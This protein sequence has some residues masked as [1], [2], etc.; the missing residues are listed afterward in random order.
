MDR[1]FLW[2]AIGA[3]ALVVLALSI[4]ST[5]A[6]PGGMFGGPRPGRFVVAHASATQVLILDTATGNIYKA[7]EKDFKAFAEIAKAVEGGG[8]PGGPFPKDGPPFG[9]DGFFGKKDGDEK[10]GGFPKKEGRKEGFGKKEGKKRPPVEKD[11]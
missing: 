2:P 10:D 6:Q 11:D 1:R 8:F 4:G 9:K 5:P 3:V 7:G